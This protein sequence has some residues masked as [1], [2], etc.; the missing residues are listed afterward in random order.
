MTI[1]TFY[2]DAADYADKKNC[3]GGHLSQDPKPKQ[4][5]YLFIYV[6]IYFVVFRKPTESSKRRRLMEEDEDEEDDDFW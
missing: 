5:I 4:L 2:E 3:S 6:L 1:V